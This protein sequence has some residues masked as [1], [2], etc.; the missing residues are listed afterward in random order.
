MSRYESGSKSRHWGWVAAGLAFLFVVVMPLGVGWFVWQQ[1]P[2]PKDV[3]TFAGAF[4]D[5]V[6]P[7][8]AALA[9]AGL[10]YTALMQREELGLQREEL[11]E[12]RAELRRTAD[13]QE[14]SEKALQA[15]VKAADLTARLNA[16]TALLEHYRST[17]PGPFAAIGD[18]V[19]WEERQAFIEARDR[20]I[21]EVLGEIISLRNELRDVV[22]FEARVNITQPTASGTATTDGS[23]TQELTEG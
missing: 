10:I 17:A 11:R 23:D 15:Q 2:P 14:A 22:T 18:A 1:L 3:S 8:F 20:N 5:I 4:G 19:A 12:T 13:A 21:E 16:A 6:G 7:L 9:F